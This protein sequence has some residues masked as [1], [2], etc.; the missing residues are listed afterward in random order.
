M[1]FLAGP[2]LRASG[3]GLIVLR[4]KPRPVTGLPTFPSVHAFQRDISRVGCPF[5]ADSFFQADAEAPGVCVL[6]WRRDPQA[7]YIGRVEA[8]TCITK[9]HGLG[10]AVRELD[11]FSTQA[12]STQRLPCLNVV[13]TQA[14]E[15]SET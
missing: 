6:A 13:G 11:V 9:M 8:V 4:G 1:V 10:I 3:F 7:S 5:T 2:A 14:V 15:Q 12:R